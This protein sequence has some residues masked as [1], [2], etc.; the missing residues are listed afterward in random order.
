M[1][2]TLMSRVWSRET[3]ELG[4]QARWRNGKRQILKEEIMVS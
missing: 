1:K 3:L 2:T 4:E